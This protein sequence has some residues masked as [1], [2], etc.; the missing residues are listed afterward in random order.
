MAGAPPQITSLAA[1]GALLVFFVSVGGAVG[2]RCAARHLRSA[3][4]QARTRRRS[5]RRVRV[6]ELLP[7]DAYV[8][9]SS[10]TRRSRRPHLLRDRG[11]LVAVAAVAQAL[12]TRY[13][14]RPVLLPACD[15]HAA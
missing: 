10:T 2:R 3:P 1:A 7:A 15:A 12:S 4:S 6:L 9:T 11:T 8:Q 5:S 13:G 14:P